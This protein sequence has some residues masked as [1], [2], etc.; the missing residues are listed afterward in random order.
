[1]PGYGASTV[2]AQSQPVSVPQPAPQALE[3]Y[4]PPVQQH[5][6]AVS[7]SQVHSTNTPILADRL[8]LQVGA[9]A[10]PDAAQLL[11]DKLS[12]LTSAPVFINS[13]VRNEQVLH[14]VRMGPVPNQNEADNLR[15]RI[16]LANLGQPT[17]VAAD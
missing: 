7:P 5:A 10:N 1:M 9:F 2:L 14:R 15:D 11:R 6:G 13:V 8:Y 12:M 16:R 4:T 3:V 17:L